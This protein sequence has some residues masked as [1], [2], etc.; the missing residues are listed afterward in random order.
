MLRILIA[1]LSIA[2]IAAASI[3]IK[4]SSIGVVATGGYRLLLAIPVLLLLQF[5]SKSKSYSDTD[6]ITGKKI[7]I[8]FAALS[9]ILFGLDLT[10]F[11]LSLSLTTAAEANLLTNLVPFV[12]APISVIF[13]KRKI[14]P[15]FLY[16]CIVALGG[17]F[18]M[19]GSHVNLQNI[20]GNLLALVSMFFYAG[21]WLAIEKASKYM[22]SANLMTIVGICGGI[23]L[24]IVAYFMGEQLVPTNLEGWVTVAMVALTGQILGQLVLTDCIEYIS[25]ELSTFLLLTQPVFAA[26]FAY[27]LFDETLSVQ[28]LCGMVLLFIAIY[29][30]KI[31]LDKGVIQN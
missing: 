21:Y 8:F 2:S 3:F 31:V 29:I 18:L 9:G 12:I 20:Q 30:A 14:S 1:L 25:V 24:F 4:M 26:I 7:G 5:F 10:F 22:V 13:L 11:N 17:L 23:T 15:K 6:V 28:Q 16:S 27:F 19:M